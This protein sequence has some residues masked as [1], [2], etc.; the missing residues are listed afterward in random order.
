MHCG[1]GLVWSGLVWSSMLLGG[2]SHDDMVPAL[3]IISDDMVPAVFVND[4]STDSY[5]Y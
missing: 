4:D 3:V 1:L 2:N 5:Y